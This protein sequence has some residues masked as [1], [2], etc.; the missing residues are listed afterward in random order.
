MIIFFLFRLL[1]HPFLSQTF[2]TNNNQ[3]QDHQIDP[4]ESQLE[5][6][7]NDLSQTSDAFGVSHS[8][9]HEEAE[10]EGEVVEAGGGERDLGD[11]ETEDVEGGR[12]GKRGGGL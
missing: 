7:H 4:N 2:E 8:E 10:Y 5:E 9:D 6:S 1:T 3:T 11:E 12:S